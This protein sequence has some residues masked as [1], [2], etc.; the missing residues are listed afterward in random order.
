MTSDGSARYP[1]DEYVLPFG[2]AARLRP[3][4]MTVAAIVFSLLP[5]LAPIAVYFVITAIAGQGEG[6]AA[7]GA[8]LGCLS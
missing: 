6:F 4:L 1:G 2:S 3:K 7:L 5:V 8:L